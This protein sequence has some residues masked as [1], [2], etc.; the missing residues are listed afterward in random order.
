MRGHVRPTLVAAAL[1]VACICAESLAA[2]SAP[3]VVIDN[4]EANIE[5]A[6]NNGWMVVAGDATDEETLR[7]AGIE[8]A[9]SL[10]TAL[11]SD[12]DNLFVTLSARTMNEDLF[13]VTRSSHQNNEAKL[14]QAGADRVLTPNVIGGTRMASM[15]LHP[16]VLDYLDL[17]MHGDSVEY[18]LQEVL[19]TD[20][21]TM[22]APGTLDPA[23]LA[24]V[25]AFELRLKNET[26]GVL[27]LSPV[28]TAAFTGEGGFKPSGD[29]VWSSAA[30]EELNDRLSRLLEGPNGK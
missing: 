21:P 24:Q 26:L 10:V 12:A 15:V 23:D 4:D 9:K 14:R 1:L 25:T 29:F 22:V 17:V 19:I 20:G 2:E 30:E 16:V 3:F 13:I 5:M 7:D 11:D 27:S 28:P 6:R 18:R 8:V